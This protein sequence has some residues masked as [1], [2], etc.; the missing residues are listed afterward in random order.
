MKYEGKTRALMYKQSLRISVMGI[1]AEQEKERLKQVHIICYFLF[2]LLVVV[3]V[4]LVY[5][6]PG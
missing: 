1:T 5:Y 3:V 6:K 4:I 2:L